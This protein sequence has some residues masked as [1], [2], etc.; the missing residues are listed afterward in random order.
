MNMNSETMKIKHALIA[1]VKDL[2]N[3]EERLQRVECCLGNEDTLDIT[4]PEELW[5]DNF[6]TVKT[7]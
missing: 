1:I 3:L 5:P 2:Q 7:D 6:I 4:P